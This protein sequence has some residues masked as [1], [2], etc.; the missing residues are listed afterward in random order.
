MNRHGFLRITCA[1]P[2]VSVADPSANAAEIIRLIALATDSD[3]LVFP[4]LCVT[5]YTCAELFGQSVL[6]EGAR[7]AVRQIALATKDRPQLVVVGSPIAVA[8]GLYNCA[9][10]ISNGGPG[11]RS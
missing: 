4:E 7:R 10:A 1:S 9:I 11:N 5:G 8:N 3:L 6:L 2:R